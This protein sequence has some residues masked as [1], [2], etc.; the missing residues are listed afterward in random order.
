MW[1]AMSRRAPYLTSHL[2]QLVGFLANP[3]AQIRLLA[4]ENLV[5]YSSSQP[6]IFKTEELKPIKHLKLLVRD[7]PVCASEMSSP[8]WS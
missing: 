2:P 3:N 5:G 8:K 6:S 7:H 1:H 4:A